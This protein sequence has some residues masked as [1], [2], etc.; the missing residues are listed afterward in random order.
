[1]IQIPTDTYFRA[2]VTT[3][4]ARGVSIR[5]F[6]KTTGIN[7]ASLSKFL[8][9][10]DSGVGIKASWCSALCLHYAASPAFLLMGYGPA[11][12]NMRQ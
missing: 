6:C 11:F 8:S 2:A 12:V 10:P 3:I 7:R 9:G 1:M 4:L 5:E